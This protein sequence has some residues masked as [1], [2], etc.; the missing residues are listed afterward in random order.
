[1][2]A[3]R[4]QQA[5]HTQHVQTLCGAQNVR[6]IGHGVDEFASRSCPNDAVF[7]KANGVRSVSF[8]RDHKRDERQ[9]HADKDNLAIADFACRSGDHQFAEGIGL[10]SRTRNR[11][12]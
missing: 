10:R 5:H 1:M 12:R 3:S 11:G 7:E 4:L 8:L 2:N 6:R 9:P